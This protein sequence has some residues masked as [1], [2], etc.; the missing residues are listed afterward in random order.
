VFIVTLSYLAVGVI[1]TVSFAFTEWEVISGY[2]LVSHFNKISWSWL[3]AIVFCPKAGAR[4]SRDRLAA[5]TLET[6]QT[7]LNNKKKLV[8]SCG[9]MAQSFSI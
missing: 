7:P 5:R 8:R 3:D 9:I 4:A 6:Y 2:T 1:V